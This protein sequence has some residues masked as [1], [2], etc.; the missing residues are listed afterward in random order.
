MLVNM[1]EMLKDAEKHN[2]AIGS[3]NTP[4]LTTLRAVVAVAEELNCPVM[5]NHAQGHEPVVQLEVIAPLMKEYAE[6][7]KIPVCMHIDHGHDLAFCM[8]AVKAGFTS[9]MY[10]RS[11]DPL[12]VNIKKIKDFI[13]LVKSV[14][15]TVEAELGAM[16]NNM[17]TVVPGQEKSDLSDLSQYFTRVDEA[18]RFC[19]ES[20]V[21]ALTISFGTV[22]GIY[23]KKSNLD[24]QRVKDIKAAISNTGTSLVMH[25]ASG[26]EPNQVIE[27]IDAG[28]RKINYFTGMDTAVAPYFTDF[29]NKANGKPVNFSILENIAMEVLYNKCKEAM[30]LFLSRKK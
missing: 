10:D 11:E 4:N 26:T 15:I 19:E 29:I 17:P 6:K 18:R 13:E 9:I 1:V 2:Y 30:Q 21:N 24:I 20:K 23:E 27:A 8:R 3:F 12:E 16:P 25:G 22:H 5:I 7:A 14:N 28:I